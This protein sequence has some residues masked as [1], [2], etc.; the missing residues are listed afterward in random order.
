MALKKHTGCVQQIYLKH[1]EPRATR[2]EKLRVW[3]VLNANGALC[4]LHHPSLT[5]GIAV[6]CDRKL[7]VK[8]ITVVLSQSERKNFPAQ[9]WFVS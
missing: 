1:L 3:H 2:R 8:K 5:K 7:L 4:C 9:S 6:A